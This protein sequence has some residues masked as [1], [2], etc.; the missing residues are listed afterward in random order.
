[1]HYILIKLYSEPPSVETRGF[2]LLVVP[3]RLEKEN[4]SVESHFDN[5]SC[6][7]SLS[8]RRQGAGIQVPSVLW[9]LSGCPLGFIP[10]KAGAEMTKDAIHLRSEKRGIVGYFRTRGLRFHG[11]S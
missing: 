4:I 8:L 2:W 5:P 3:I 1:M 6:P 11:I 10:A 9:W 7:R